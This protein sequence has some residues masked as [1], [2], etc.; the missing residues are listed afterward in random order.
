MQAYG[1]SCTSTA[2]RFPSAAKAPSILGCYAGF[3]LPATLPVSVPTRLAW[4][5]ATVDWT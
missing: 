2:K 1:V 3:L 4:R 5:D